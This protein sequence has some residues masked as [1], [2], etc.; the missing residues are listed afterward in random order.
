MKKLLIAAG[1]IVGLLLLVVIAV[2][3]FFDGEKFRPMAESEAKKALGREVKI[4]KLGVS[5]WN[6]GAV[7]E[8]ITV[9]DDP[10][11]SREPFV[12]A[13]EM[14]IGVELMP[15]LTSKEI[16]ITTVRL[17]EPRISLIKS[18][19]GKWNFEGLGAASSRTTPAAPGAFSVGSVKIEDGIIV[20]RKGSHKS[21]YSEV[22]LSVSDF[23]A[24]SNFPFEMKA[25]TPGGGKLEADGRAGPLVAG[26]AVASPIKMD[27][28]VKG[29]DLAKSGFVDPASGIGGV[30]DFAGKAVSDGKKLTAEGKGTVK[31]LKVAAG[32]APATQPVTLDLAAD[33]DPV[34]NQGRI[35][36][37]DI[38]VGSSKAT[39]T[40]TM[41]TKGETVVVK[42]KLDATSMK[43]DDIAGLLPA[44]GIVLPSGAQLKGGTASTNLNIEGSLDRLVISGP[45]NVSGTTLMGFDA[46]KSMSAVAGLAGVNVGKNIDIQT[47][48][49]GLRYGPEGIRLDGIQLVAPAIGSMNGA[50]TIS[51]SHALDF[52]MRAKLAGGGGLVGGLAALTSG[53]QNAGEVPFMIKG[54]TSAPVFLPDIGSLATGT[55]KTPANI[56]KETITGLGGLFGKKKK[57]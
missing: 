11:F 56:G 51:P 43:V 2:P 13:K 49:S 14:T 36:K 44:L 47:L 7:A 19:A 57:Q 15:Y 40:G 38:T 52:K 24:A 22:K 32:G 8:D 41:N 25:A 35:T 37:G 21:E 5:V 17:K 12:K 29:L 53:G 18:A 55:I 42:S 54:T 39:L 23:S 16:K 26:N 3:L 31:K 46:K 48:A 20:V 30:M 10:A 27:I 4:G 33:L 28:D 45:L 9:A 50:G 34:T 6:M 1:V